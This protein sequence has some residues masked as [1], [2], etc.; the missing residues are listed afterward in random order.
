MEDKDFLGYFSQLAPPSTIDQIKTA[1]SK[2]VATLVAI[3]SVAGRKGSTD[4]TAKADDKVEKS[5]KK[6]Y[7]TGDLGE[8]VSADL[9]YTLK[10]LVR[11]LNSENHAVKQGFFL[12]GV[13]VLNKF[14]QQ[15]DF[16]KYLKY[17]FNETKSASGMKSSEVNNAAMGRMMCM[18]ACVEARIFGHGAQINPRILKVIVGCLTELY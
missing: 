7:L 13:L 16:D 14:K 12:A 10:R 15:I 1:A 3:G 4:S 5:I 6:K 11:G 18:S 8:K 9:N 17:A 2:I